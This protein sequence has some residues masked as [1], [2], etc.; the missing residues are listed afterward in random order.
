MQKRGINSEFVNKVSITD[1]IMIYY[2]N[3]VQNAM[4]SL[5]INPPYNISENGIND[6]V[7]LFFVNKYRDA[8]GIKDILSDSFKKEDE[9]ETCAQKLLDNFYKKFYANYYSNVDSKLPNEIAIE[10]KYIN[11]DTF[12]N[13]NKVEY[14]GENGFIILMKILDKLNIKY[15]IPKN[16][17]YLNTGSYN[18]FFYSSLIPHYTL[19]LDELELKQSL[20]ITHNIFHSI[21]NTPELSLYF[22]VKNF[23]FEYG[24]YSID[25]NKIF[26]TG[27]FKINT[28]FLRKLINYDSTVNIS[29]ILNH[30]NLN[31]L[32]YLSK[33]REEF[34]DFLKEKPII[35][36]NDKIIYK[37]FTTSD[38]KNPA[39]TYEQFLTYFGNWI[40]KK[41]FY[42]KVHY[43]VELDNKTIKFYIKI[44]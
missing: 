27:K 25:T 29:S 34:K 24:F 1:P 31:N 12:I 5:L 23:V 21:Q 28:P 42:D 22:S 40:L 30:T 11:Y 41:R 2:F 44:K 39:T 38:F 18:L 9:Y 4:K 35:I 37:T 36:I 16:K 17:R 26:T 6:F 15:I 33:I 19:L 20:K 13:E 3:G 10:R 8:I 32:T 7:N 43:S 14:D